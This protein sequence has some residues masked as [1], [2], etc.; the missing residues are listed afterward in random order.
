MLYAENE[1]VDGLISLSGEG[2]LKKAIDYEFSDEQLKNFEVKGGAFYKNWS[3]DGEMELLG[4]QFLDDMKKYST[5]NAAINISCPV[6]FIHGTNDDVIPDVASKEM[7][8]LVKEESDLILLKDVDHMYN[9]FS[10][11]TKVGDVINYVKVWL[12][13]KK[14]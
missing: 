14:F 13:N 1:K 8:E 10:N 6:L 5:K 4:K 7:F 9:V 2:D 11:N 3:N 12:K